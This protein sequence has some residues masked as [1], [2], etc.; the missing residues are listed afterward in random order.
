MNPDS[1]PLGDIVNTT[2]NPNVNTAYSTTLIV[3][4]HYQDSTHKTEKHSDTQKVR[5][6][7]RTARASGAVVYVTKITA[8]IVSNAL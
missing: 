8:E 3:T 5:D 2:H 7:I 6:D 1:Y 4:Y